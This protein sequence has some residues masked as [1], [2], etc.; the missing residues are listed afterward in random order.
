MVKLNLL[1]D[2]PEILAFA[3]LIIGFIVALLAGSAVVAYIIIFLCGGAF[4]RLWFKLRGKLK[5]PWF[6]III[7]F[8]IGFLL[9]SYYGSR[10]IILLL[11]IAGLLVSYYLHEKK[12]I[13]SVEY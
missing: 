7:G 6:I 12:I 2:W 10:G 8:I 1:D 4:G 9:G 11:F 5:V 3:L 13:R